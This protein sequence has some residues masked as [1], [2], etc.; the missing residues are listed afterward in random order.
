MRVLTLSYDPEH[1]LIG[2]SFSMSKQFVQYL[3]YRIKPA[4]RRY[5]SKD[6]KWYVKDTSINTLVRFGRICF[7]RIVYKDLPAHL[8]IKIADSKN[9]AIKRAIIGDSPY[10][11]LHLQT[12]APLV[13]VKAAYKALAH[14]HHPDKGGS[15][16]AF[17]QINN[18]YVEIC[19]E[20]EH[21]VN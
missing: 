6:R 21:A 17:T 14:L 8:Q 15:P 19:E 18:A 9:N 4:Q 3:K 2:C 16:E 11:V 20:K 13:V 7:D 10:Q 1:R 5:D 12:S